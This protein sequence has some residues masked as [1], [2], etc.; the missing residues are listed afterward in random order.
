[1]IFETLSRQ[2]GHFETAAEHF[3]HRTWPQGTMVISTS[4]V[5]Q[6]R[7]SQAA[8]AVSASLA[9]ALDLSCKIDPE[10]M[11]DS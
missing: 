2:N 3:R 5:K 4:E 9:A 8:F 10:T 11:N 6:T 1:M 7:Q